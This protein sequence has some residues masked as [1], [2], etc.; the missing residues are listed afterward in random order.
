MKIFAERSKS[1]IK[2]PSKCQLLGY[3]E[4]KKVKYDMKFV[5]KNA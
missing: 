1:Y 2:I 4:K 3:K 5:Q